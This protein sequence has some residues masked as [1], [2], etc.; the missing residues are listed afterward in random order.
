MS[1]SAGSKAEGEDS[2]VRVVPLDELDDGGRVADLAI[3]QDEDLAKVSRPDGLLENGLQR[4]VDLGP[5]IVCVH[6]LGVLLCLGKT[7][8]V[9][10]HAAV[11]Q[12]IEVRAEAEENET[13]P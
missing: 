12:R 3:R 5:A 1:R 10:L 13:K 8:V 9:V 6:G 7:V 4:L 2:S 11:E